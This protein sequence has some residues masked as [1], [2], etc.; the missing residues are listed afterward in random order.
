VKRRKTWGDFVERQREKKKSWDDCENRTDWT[1]IRKPLGTSWSEGGSGCSGLKVIT[2]EETEE[3][4][5]R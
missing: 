5:G 3:Q 2:A 4:E 1:L